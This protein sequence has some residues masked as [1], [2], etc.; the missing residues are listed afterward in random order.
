MLALHLEQQEGAAG[1]AGWYGD[2][3]TS[4]SPQATQKHVQVSFVGW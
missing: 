2:A 3:Q 4:T 1:W